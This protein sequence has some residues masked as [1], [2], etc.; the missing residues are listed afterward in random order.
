MAISQMFTYVTSS[1]IVF[2]RYGRASR[3]ARAV[4]PRRPEG[5]DGHL[6]H[7]MNRYLI[8]VL[9]VA[10]S[11]ILGFLVTPLLGAEAPMFTFVLGVAIAAR[12]SGRRAAAEAGV[13][14]VGSCGAAR[15][16]RRARRNRVPLGLGRLHRS[17][18]PSAAV[19]DGARSGAAA[20][21]RVRGLL[22]LRNQPALRRLPVV[23]LTSSSQDSDV[24]RAYDLGANSH[25]VK[26]SGLKQIDARKPARFPC[27]A[28]RCR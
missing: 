6:S 18:G 25:V 21:V 1:T 13:P 3:D 5:T 16:R 10:G 2:T 9:A 27:P 20:G 24:N 8:A 14:L 11:A 17:E 23:V 15:R 7:L 28:D 26:P 19:G 4:Q 12:Q 22:W